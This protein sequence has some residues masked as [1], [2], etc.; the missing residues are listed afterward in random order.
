MKILSKMLRGFKKK[1]NV[2]SLY[3]YL[4]TRNNKIIFQKRLKKIIITLDFEW[5]Y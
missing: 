1:R 2:L 5:L 4:N 3:R